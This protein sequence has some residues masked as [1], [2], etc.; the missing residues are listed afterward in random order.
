MTINEVQILEF[1][2]FFEARSSGSINALNIY[3]D[4]K[5]TRTK[6]FTQDF[7]LFQGKRRDK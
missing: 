5:M 3:T 1:K 7:G 6:A 4:Q 2:L